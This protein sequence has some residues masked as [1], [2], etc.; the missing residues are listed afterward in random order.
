MNSNTITQSYNP[1][2]GLLS[3][4]LESGVD[5]FF[6]KNF[7]TGI[8]KQ[9]GD[10]IYDVA[11]ARGKEGSNFPMHSQGNGIANSGLNYLGENAFASMDFIN[12]ATGETDL[13]TFASYGSPISKDVFQDTIDQQ[14]L[15]Y[16]GTETHSGDAVGEVLGGNIGFNGEL[17][18]FDRILALGGISDLFSEDSPH[19]TYMCDANFICGDQ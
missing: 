8:A 7:H 5:K 12:A 18:L 15:I 10:F 14:S 6:G 3:D 4:I 2:H 11:E 16:L 13:P 17:S 9:T 19:S 1:T